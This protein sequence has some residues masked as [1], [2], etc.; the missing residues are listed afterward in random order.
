MLLKQH[1]TLNINKGLRGVLRN[2]SMAVWYVSSLF[3]PPYFGGKVQRC[4]YI[5]RSPSPPKHALQDYE[6]AKDVGARAV[7]SGCFRV[8]DRHGC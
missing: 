8:H 6:E 2:N 3:S 4:N 7:I 5:S 1:F